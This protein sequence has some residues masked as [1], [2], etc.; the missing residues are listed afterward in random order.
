MSSQCTAQPVVTAEK[1]IEYKRAYGHLGDFRAPETVLVCYQ[2]STMDYLLKQYPEIRPS[3][4]VSH[5]HLLPDERAGILGDWGVGAP[6][7]A[8]KLEELIALGAK[9]F[10]A[11]GTAGGLLDSHKIG[12]LILC[13]KALAE[14]GVAPL[15]LPAG[16]SFAEAGSQILL[17]WGEFSKKQLIP[18]MESATAWSFSA[19]FRET[20]EDVHRV[21]SLGCS[22]VEMEAATLY[23]IGREKGVQTMSLFVLSDTIANGEWIPRPKEP[24]LLDRLHQLANLALAFTMSCN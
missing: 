7:L 14:D 10:L 20:A 21:V 15:Y 13:P 18:P 4:A 3:G 24:I 2:R 16:Q 9:R 8:I 17:E 6:G 11:I 22:V 12:D 1:L 23:A 5:F 19:L